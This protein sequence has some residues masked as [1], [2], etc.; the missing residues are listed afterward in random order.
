MGSRGAAGVREFVM[1]LSREMGV[2]G[3]VFF[4]EAFHGR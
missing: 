4:G 1:R 2:P 3:C